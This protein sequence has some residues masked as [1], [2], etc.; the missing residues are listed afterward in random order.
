MKNYSVFHIKNRRHPLNNSY[1][2]ILYRL[3]FDP[4]H[5]FMALIR[6]LTKGKLIIFFVSIQLKI[7]QIKLS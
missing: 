7:P 4:L 1:A 5:T 2:S 6:R 3:Y